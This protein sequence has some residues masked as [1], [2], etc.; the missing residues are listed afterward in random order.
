MPHA[1][2]PKRRSTFV[3]ERTSIDAGISLYITVQPSWVVS[4]SVAVSDVV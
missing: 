2:G 3:T 4:L 1:C